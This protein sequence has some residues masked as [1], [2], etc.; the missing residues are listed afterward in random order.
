MKR[1]INKVIRRIKHHSHVYVSLKMQNEQL[2]KFKNIHQGKDCIIMGAGPSL[3]EIPHD[4]LKKFVVIGTNLSFKYYTPDYW[5]VIDAQYS[6]MEEG[7]KLCREKNI[8]AFINWLWAPD[9]P[10][11]IHENEISL[12]P[13][14]ISTEQSPKNRQLRKNLLNTFNDPVVLEKKGVTSVNSV[15]PEGAIPIAAY[16][17]FKRI[18][19]S[20]VDFYTPKKGPLHFIEDAKEDLARIDK[21]KKNIQK[22]DNTQKDLFAYKRWP[23]E[24]VGKS[25][26]KDRVF[27]LSEKS[28]VKNIPKINFTEVILDS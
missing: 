9:F 6:W 7:R 15:V 12:H 3:N 1:Y 17:G 24:L 18:F 21:L 20:G 14:R 16:M 25:K 26:L 10:D 28:T 2:R 13:Y 19:L 27:N 22:A 5:V 11:E 4:F 8:P 23:I